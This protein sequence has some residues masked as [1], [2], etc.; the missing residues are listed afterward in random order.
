MESVVAVLGVVTVIAAGTWFQYRLSR[1][2]MWTP[3]WLAFSATATSILF[4]VAG[5]L[6]VTLS[7]RSRFLSGDAASSGV[8][9]WEVGVGLALSV[10]SLIL[11]RQGI[12][13]IRR[14]GV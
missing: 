11:W 7:K 9:W 4:I 1:G 6:G 14:R 2:R 10:V 8:I 5:T 3:L 13:S 12:Q